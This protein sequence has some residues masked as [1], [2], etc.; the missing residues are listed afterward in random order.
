MDYKEI[1][2]IVNNHIDEFK[3]SIN[4]IEYYFIT[5]NMTG[6]ERLRYM[7]CGVIEVYEKYR[8]QH[9]RLHISQPDNRQEVNGE[10]SI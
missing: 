1:K 4:K 6:E 3:D 10:D 2:D 7:I 5:S 9:D 8:R